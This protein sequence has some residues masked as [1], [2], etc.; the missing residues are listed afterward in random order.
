MSMRFT[1]LALV[2][3]VLAGCGGGDGGGSGI[4]VPPDNT[5]YTQLASTTATTPTQLRFLGTTSD[6]GRTNGNGGSFAHNT[7]TI[8]G[9]QFA[10]TINN[11]RTEIDLNAGGRA[12][13]SNPGTTEFVRVFQT[14]GS[15][16]PL[17]GVV[18]Q[19]TAAG[20]V[21]TGGSTTYNGHIDVTVAD[22]NTVDTLS[23]NAR[24]TAS[25]NSGQVD[26]TFNSFQRGN[27]DVSGSI[28]ID[29]ARVSGNAF[30]GGSLSTT[31][32]TFDLQ[33]GARLDGTRGEFFGPAANEVGGVLVINGT[34]S[35]T[36][37]II[38]VFSAD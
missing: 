14:E 22:G 25:W 29:N 36:P 15:G 7:N 30:T 6:A 35:G 16:T 11:G 8:S 12:L 37:R 3:P 31:G 21:P 33:G 1:V 24:I 18:G 26:S 9:G 34:G 4:T 23:G 27:T 10:G 28:T 32:D 20:G 19:A 17:F 13:L 5:T 2:A 38:G